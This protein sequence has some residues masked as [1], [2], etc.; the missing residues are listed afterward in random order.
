MSF[1]H[2]P[3]TLYRWQIKIIIYNIIVKNIKLIS[4]LPWCYI[5]RKKNKNKYLLKKI[6]FLYKLVKINTKQSVKIPVYQLKMK[7]EDS[8]FP[9]GLTTQSMQNALL[10][11]LR[12]LEYTVLWKNISQGK[13]LN[14]VNTCNL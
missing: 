8:L 10:K 5:V 6:I 14:S 13:E 11:V 7:W 4:L 2:G 3:E 12:G 9:F 1:S